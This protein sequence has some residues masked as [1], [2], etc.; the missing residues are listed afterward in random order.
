MSI[1]ESD[2]HQSHHSYS[3]YHQ[4]IPQVI[5]SSSPYPTKSNKILATKSS[6]KTLKQQEHSEKDIFLSP[7]PSPNFNNILITCGNNFFFIIVS[8]SGSK[9]EHLFMLYS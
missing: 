2:C 9:N 3:A 1:I 8:A 5:M 6:A 7:P 4:Y